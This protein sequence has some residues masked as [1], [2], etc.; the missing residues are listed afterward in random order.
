MP[1]YSPRAG[2]ITR[3]RLN[4]PFGKRIDN[5]NILY[6]PGNAPGLTRAA[7]ITVNGSGKGTF[8]YVLAARD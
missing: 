5:S 6:R 3:L 2:F 1:R 8:A 4:T 7:G